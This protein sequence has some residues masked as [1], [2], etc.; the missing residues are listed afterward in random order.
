MRSIDRIVDSWT[1]VSMALIMMADSV[2]CKLEAS[3]QTVFGSM[4]Q[5]IH[6]AWVD[7][8]RERLE[9]MVGVSSS[10]C[11]C[12]CLRIF[13]VRFTPIK[14]GVDVMLVVWIMVFCVNRL[15]VVCFAILCDEERRPQG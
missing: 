10:F 12:V 4:D 9:M 14:E 6:F 15:V 3:Y 5:S 2:Q 11:S 13:R 8:G 7:G 1:Q